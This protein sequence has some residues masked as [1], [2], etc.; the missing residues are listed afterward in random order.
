VGIKVTFL[1]PGRGRRSAFRRRPGVSLAAAAASAVLVLGVA[2]VTTTVAADAAGTG[3]LVKDANFRHGT[4]AWKV[5]KGARVYVSVHGHAGHRAIAVRNTSKRA[6][7]FNINDRVN[8]VNRTVAGRTYTASAWVKIGRKRVTAAVREGAWRGSTSRGSKLASK[9]LTDHRWHKITVTFRART[10]DASIDLNFLAW[11][12]PRKATI[13]VSQPTLV[14][15]G[16]ATAAKPTPKPTPPTTPP[17]PPVT[18]P[19]SPP[20]TPPTTPPTSPPTSP[21]TNPGLRLVFDDEF[22][23][24]SVDRGKWNVRNNWA[25]GNEL[26]VATSRTQNVSEAG[27][28]LTIHALRE[29]YSTGSTTRD[30]TSGYLDTIGR[31]SLKY[32]RWEIRAKLPTAQGLWP[33]FWLRGDSTVG[34]I[35]ILE[36]IGGVPG[37]V[38]QTVHQS[39]NGDMD[40]SGYEAKP[41]GFDP[42]QWHTYALERDPDGTLRWYIDDKLTRQRTPSDLDNQGKPMTWLNGDTFSSPWNI[43][44]NLQVG[45]SMPAY[46]NKQVGSTSRL[47]D[48][49][50]VDWVRVYQG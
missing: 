20:T 7:T 39:T 30:Y 48:S 44:L 17:A 1:P 2:A 32:G 31:S 37:T 13:Y 11:K 10:S 25:A 16:R 9:W 24:A 46:F 3:N 28:V 40:K 14:V 5:T 21:P 18:P 15:S 4:Y 50:Q 34:E 23:G 19:T 6:K 22:D 49:Y 27:G 33:A 43:R 38:V 26:S 35:D 29:Q 45:G 8:T 12:L 42:A 47:P 41:A 36:A